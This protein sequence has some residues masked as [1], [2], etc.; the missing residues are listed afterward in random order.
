MGA[1]DDCIKQYKI[2][3]GQCGEV[4]LSSTIAPFARQF[5]GVT[6]G[7]CAEQGYTVYDHTETVSVGPFG[8]FDTDIYLKPSGKQS[9]ASSYCPSSGSAIHAGCDMSYSFSDSCDAVVDEIEARI[10]GQPASWHD[11]HNN[12][13]YTLGSSSDGFL[14]ISR[15]T[16]DQKYTDK[17]NFEL[18]STDA[19]CQVNAC[20]E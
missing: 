20:S 5:G 8:D 3:D 15:T 18:T 11:P 16:G 7:T 10:N 13:T 17:M 2:E 6:D 12:G 9:T 1:E 4:C 19:G 14:S